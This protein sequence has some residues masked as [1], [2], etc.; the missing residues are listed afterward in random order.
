MRNKVKNT[1]QY[2]GAKEESFSQDCQSS[3]SGLREAYPPLHTR[4]SKGSKRPM[5]IQ[6]DLCWDPREN[7]HIVYST[8]FKA[9]YLSK[10]AKRHGRRGG[11][12][13]ASKGVL[14]K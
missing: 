6:F 13:Q 5:G 12:S 8:D 2:G 7:A 1:I 14:N 4:C 10:E 11:Y 3:K 9:P